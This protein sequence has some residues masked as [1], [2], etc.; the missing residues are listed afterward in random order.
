M[1]KGNIVQEEQVLFRNI[2]NDENLTASGSSG[3]K[4][5]DSSISFYTGSQNQNHKWRARDLINKKMLIDF[6][7]FS[8]RNMLMKLNIN[9]IQIYAPLTTPTEVKDFTLKQRALLKSTKKQE[10]NIKMGD[11]YSKIGLDVRNERV[12]Q[13]L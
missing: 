13:L 4:I 11:I 3:K 8:D 6:V 10:I 5:D 1:Y 12:N 2:R 7:S 9:L